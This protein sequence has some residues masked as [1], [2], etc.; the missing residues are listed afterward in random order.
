MLI[1]KTIQIEEDFPVD[2][3]TNMSMHKTFRWGIIKQYTHL[4]PPQPTQ[5]NA[6]LTITH[7]K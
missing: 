1:F 4:H 7:P 2:R 5:N 6:P 3:T